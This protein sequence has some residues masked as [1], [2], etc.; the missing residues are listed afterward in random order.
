LF[1]ILESMERRTLLC[2]GGEHDLVLHAAMESAGTPIVHELYATPA[3]ARF[4]QPLEALPAP[5]GNQRSYLTLNR[6]SPF[7]VDTAGIRAALRRAPMEFTAAARSGALELSLPTPD[8]TVQ[9]FKVVETQVLAPDLAARFPKIKTYLAR[10]IDDPTA[11]ARID[12]NPYSGLHAMVWSEAGTW[13]IDPY[14]HQ[15]TTAFVS[16]RKADLVRNPDFLCETEDELEEGQDHEG[17][18]GPENIPA[19]DVL[20]TFRLAVTTTTAYNSFH[21]NSIPSVLSAVTTAV[22][23]ITGVYELDLST[24][25]QL[26]ANT[27]LL[28]SNLNGNPNISTSTSVSTLANANQAFTD[29][30]IG[31]ANYDVGHVFASG[32]N[33]GVSAGGIGIVGSSAKARACSMTSPPSGDL[34][35]VDYVAHEMGHQFNGRHNFSNCSGPGDSGSIANEPGSGA[36]IMGY[37]GLCGSN[38]L[39]PNSDAMFNHINYNQMYPFIRNTIAGVGTTTATGNNAPNVNAGADYVIPARTPYALAASGTD[40]DGDPLTWSWEQMDTGGSLPVNNLTGTT[41]PVVRTWLPSSS[42][43]RTIPRP[44]NLLNNSTATGEVL[45]QVGR[46]MNFRVVARDGRGGVNFDQMSVQTIN[47]GAAFAVTSPNTSGLTWNAGTTQTVSWNVAGTDASPISTAN[48]NIA[49]SIDGG[50]TY[51]ITLASG[52]ANDGSEN[53]VVPANL[54]S[55]ARVRVEAVGNIYFD[56]SNFNLTIAAAPTTPAQPVLAAGSDSGISSSDRITNFDNSTPAKALELSVGGT[57]AGATVTVYADGVAI[58]SAIATGTTTTVIT[59]GA[60]ALANGVRNITARQTPIGE[61]QSPDSVALAV[62]ID[63]VAP[64]L[65]GAPQYTFATAPHALVYDFSE[66]VGATVDAADFVV[67]KLPGSPVPVSVSYNSGTNAA[68]L[69]FTAATNGIL[70][71]GRYQSVLSAAGVT[72]VAGNGMAADDV[73]DFFFLMGDADHDGRVNLN[74]FNILAANFGQSGRDFTQGDFDYSGNVNLND[75]NLLASRFGAVLAAPSSVAGR[76][77]SALPP[78]E[79]TGGLDGEQRDE[80]IDLLS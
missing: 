51:P 29:G 27:D 52:T 46:F 12:T 39:Q 24:R 43:T 69:S 53:I 72:D 67:L 14:F 40:P 25:L 56:I 64:A 44:I 31:F 34:F 18:G 28:F 3:A 42:P 50:N 7:T 60:T 57:L 38:N 63:T 26:V 76:P 73:L 78:G 71:D 9:R 75:F 8:G 6:Y 70:D 5:K 58:G 17:E 65:A 68:T 11:T 4:F 48:V 45:T 13:A 62:T 30:R 20:R 32:P 37:A 74:D 55:L 80:L 77:G 59:D 19:G 22:N 35:A 47:T 2:A 61:P 79:R 49:L 66:D 54:T 10:G 33:N 15:D 1:G 23:R 41:G 16:Y 21:G 36:T